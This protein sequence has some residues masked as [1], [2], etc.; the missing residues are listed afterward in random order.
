MLFYQRFL[1]ISQVVWSAYLFIKGGF[2]VSDYYLMV[3]QLS[4]ILFGSYAVY[5]IKK[6]NFNLIPQPKKK[7]VLKTNGPYKFIRHPMYLSLLICCFIF[8]FDEFSLYKLTAFICLLVT[9]ILKLELEEKLLLK[10]FEAYKEY[11][12]QSWKLIPYIY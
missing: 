2:L 4:S 8:V 3:L 10:H 12:E 11:Q 9:L 5:Y 1:V 6:G 7:G